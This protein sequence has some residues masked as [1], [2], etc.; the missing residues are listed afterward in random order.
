MAFLLRVVAVTTVTL[1]T[2]SPP[3]VRT[4]KTEGGGR[5][6]ISAAGT[7][8]TDDIQPLIAK[9][10]KFYSEKGLSEEDIQKYL[11][12][13][14]RMVRS[15][16]EGEGGEETEGQPEKK[17]VPPGSCLTSPPSRKSIERDT[18]AAC[19]PGLKET[20]FLGGGAFGRVVAVTLDS[21]T[22][23]EI[24]GQLPF[25]PSELEDGRT[26]ALK[27]MNSGM[28]RP[29]GEGG[30][31]S[32]AMSHEMALKEMCVAAEAA[33]AGVGPEVFGSWFCEI[34]HPAGKAYG[35]VLYGLLLME[36]LETTVEKAFEEV[37]AKDLI[38][39]P[40][41]QR[42]LLGLHEKF[43]NI[44][45]EHRDKHY[46]NHGIDKKGRMRLLDFGLV[47]ARSGV[48]ESDWRWVLLS[49][50]PR[51]KRSLDATSYFYFE[52]KDQHREDNIAVQVETALEMKAY[53]WGSLIDFIDKKVYPFPKNTKKPPDGE[54]KDQEEKRKERERRTVP[55]PK[56]VKALSEGNAPTSPQDTLLLDPAQVPIPTPSAS[57]G[58]FLNPPRPP[59]PPP[60][61]T[62]LSGDILPRTERGWAPEEIRDA[63][64]TG[65]RKKRKEKGKGRR[66]GTG[67]CLS[68]PPDRKRITKQK[69]AECHPG[70]IEEKSL[71][72][73]AYGTVTSVSVDPSGVK[74][75]GLFSGVRQG[76]TFALKQ[77]VADSWKSLGG[78]MEFWGEVSEKE[79]LREMC[80]GEEAGKA[81]IG[82]SVFGSWFCEVVPSA[83]GEEEKRVYGFL[84]METLQKSLEESLDEAEK[85]NR[86]VIADAQ[87]SL[88][89]LHERFFEKGYVHVDQ[90][91]GNVGIDMEG[92][93]RLLDFGIVQSAAELEDP[94]FVL[95]APAWTL[96]M[97]V[98]RLSY[99]S[100]GQH[101]K[102]NV[103][104]QVFREVQAKTYKWGGMR[105]FVDRRVFPF[106][107]DKR[108]REEERRQEEPHN[109]QGKGKDFSVTK[110]PESGDNKGT[111]REEDEAS[112][113]DSA[114]DTLFSDSLIPRVAREFHFHREKGLS[115][116]EAETLMLKAT[117]DS[118]AKEEEKGEKEEEKGEKE[119]EKDKCLGSHPPP[120]PKIEASRLKECHPGLIEKKSLGQGAFG[121]VVAVS[122]DP[123]KGA[124]ND[125]LYS[126]LKPGK[127]YALKQM[128]G[129]KWESPGG[130]VSFS[131]AASHQKVLKEICVADAASDAGVGPLMFGSWFCEVTRKPKEGKSPRKRLHAFM[132]MEELSTPMRKA[133]D[134]AA[135]ENLIITPDAQR[136]ILGLHEKFSE[137]GYIQMDPHFENHGVAVSGHF[138]LLD[139]GLVKPSGECKKETEPLEQV[140]PGLAWELESTDYF[141][142]GKHEEENVAKEVQKEIKEERYDWGKMIPFVDKEVYP[143]PKSNKGNEQTQQPAPFPSPTSPSSPSS[144]SVSE[145]RDASLEAQMQEDI[146]PH[147]AKEYFFHARQGKSPEEIQR[148]I[149]SQQK[150]THAKGGE[151]MKEKGPA[152][153]TQL[154][155]SSF[156]RI[157]R[158]NMTG[159]HSGLLEKEGGKLGAG[160]FGT[161]TEVYL[162]PSSDGEGP[163]FQGLKPN[164]T[165]A[166]KRMRT[167]HWTDPSGHV[168]FSKE[169]SHK[170]TAKEMCIAREAG[171][172]EVGPVVYGS[173]FCAVTSKGK[174]AM[175][176]GFILM[177]KLE[178]SL[179]DAFTKAQKD[180]LIITPDAQRSVMGLHEQFY[181]K[182][183]VHVDNHFGNHGVD[184]SGRFRLIDFGIVY[185]H[186]FVSGDKTNLVKT[187]AERLQGIMRVT[188]Y[189][190]DGGHEE[191]NVARKTEDQIKNKTYEWGT[192]IP[193]TSEVVYPFPQNT[194]QRAA[195]GRE[196]K[197]QPTDDDAVSRVQRQSSRSTRDAPTPEPPPPPMRTFFSEEIQPRIAKKFQ[198]YAHQ[199]PSLSPSEIKRQTLHPLSLPEKNR[200]EDW[201]PCFTDP[202]PQPQL[203]VFDLE[204]CHPGL[205]ERGLLGKGV[206]GRV[207]SVSVNMSE[208]ASRNSLYSGLEPGKTY[209][210]KQM[211]AGV[212]ESRDGLVSFSAADAFEDALQEMC[213]G[214]EAGEAHVGSLVHG[215]WFCQVKEKDPNNP[216]VVLNKELYGFILM[217]Q[218]QMPLA[219]AF[220]QAVTENRIITPDAQQSVLGLHEKFFEMGYIQVDAHFNNA[221]VDMEGRFH[222]MDF[223]IV[224]PNTYMPE[225]TDGLKDVCHVLESSLRE[226]KYFSDG[227]HEGENEAQRV[228]REIEGKQYKWGSM[229]GAVEK[230]VYPFPRNEEEREGRRK[231]FER[232]NAERDGKREDAQPQQTVNE[233]RNAA[234]KTPAGS[235]AEKKLNE[236]KGTEDVRPAPQE[237][238]QENNQT[239]FSADLLPRS[240]KRRRFYAQQGRTAEVVE[241]ASVV[242][243]EA[244]QGPL[245]TLAAASHGGSSSC[246]ASPPPRQKLEKAT[247]K[248]CHPGLREERILGGGAFGTVVRVSVDS[249]QGGGQILFSG[250]EAGRTYALKHFDGGEWHGQEE[251]GKIE[252]LSSFFEALQE[253]CLA[254]VA[255]GAEKK[256]GPPVLGAWFC[257]V[258]GGVE[259]DASEKRG[260]EKRLYGFILMEE[261]QT[262]LID[263]FLKAQKNNLI[264][265]PDAQ[266]SLMGLH[267]ES[268]QSGFYQLDAHYGNV[269]VDQEGRFRL[270]DFGVVKASGWAEGKKESEQAEKVVEEYKR[271]L[272]GVARS[273]KSKLSV[274]PYF[275][276]EKHQKD[277]VARQV[278]FALEEG[279]YTFGSQIPSINKIVFP[280]PPNEEE[281]TD[282]SQEGD[283]VE[284]VTKATARRGW[285]GSSALAE[286]GQKK[287]EEANETPRLR[288]ASFPPAPAPGP[289]PIIVPE[290]ELPPEEAIGKGLRSKETV[291]QLFL[292]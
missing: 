123:S 243:K 246:F 289:T 56:E 264:I 236:R 104:A 241:N 130:L 152:C 127:T 224:R 43:F 213:I 177:E 38:I 179:Q 132:L 226:T 86:I 52:D 281:N 249:S 57:T 116:K 133:F 205:E 97:A 15:S 82:P 250:L 141:S 282:E 48:S 206:F 180:N 188:D 159:C 101:A 156:P 190:V 203:G 42:S 2:C 232:K 122:L 14:S 90:H 74:E 261:L 252:K 218:L 77:M 16:T 68:A 209:A 149:L 131:A 240:A 262:N 31:F 45:Y 222:L 95:W 93:L 96:K 79:I 88:L 247:L 193:F 292:E 170:S 143:F 272:M 286:E 72:K 148:A 276:S 113:S 85:E 223:G 259:L 62:F 99:F 8:L 13:S 253:M 278:L 119:E 195:A 204:D 191:D 1:V 66:A 94:R 106:P 27:V 53:K 163:L 78:E 22:G 61:S 288:G 64:L 208:A 275:V 181:E 257:E 11:L 167:E 20:G 216:D 23:S 18:L 59:P 112:G 46:G 139:F 4:H 84:L 239:L 80:V 37:S 242:E 268:F 210:L 128:N 273:L 235:G 271:R 199:N 287:K 111:E 200:A 166:L 81:G 73:G 255:G 51:L 161:V 63:A 169:I 265:T 109:A 214:K 220:S 267:E 25:S 245:S 234:T 41:A 150:M 207:V 6:S 251:I 151:K 238:S 55:V 291:D 187:M 279:T 44:G 19:H 277:N 134:K 120:R 290:G 202:P 33:E 197:L 137:A 75:E 65:R 118:E 158:S 35:R 201:S 58:G 192:M 228:R 103:A 173:W 145:N 54:E 185:G 153:L 108:E 70:L 221:G 274:T 146:L 144:A 87:R 172:A 155:P 194:K 40:D 3:P 135:F 26:Y 285:V 263:A 67:G 157:F 91:L 29:P 266:R 174:I 171:E 47:E 178:G 114:E 30:G 168:T 7:F 105:R 284:Y 9:K 183:Y 256:F 225:K 212:W 117:G 102:E 136:S 237:E 270:I 164:T 39:T 269:G 244:L 115:P 162:D 17:G 124:R 142:G 140:L 217:E 175:D 21:P 107:K 50:I 71:G 69:L 280:F 32:A 165:Y 100:R 98:E 198:F 129:G 248:E 24:E 89:G 10:F 260:E 215:S 138:R 184:L 160:A 28:W 5:A 110:V 227:K 49:V 258:R 154:E 211:N 186:D 121:R 12:S 76:Q 219:H 34:E 182:G 233:R 60:V 231:G 92:R 147:V 283:E 36:E 176:F 254:E 83:E 126:G 189:Y 230:V 196:E 125:S 229:I